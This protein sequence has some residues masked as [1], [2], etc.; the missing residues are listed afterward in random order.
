MM[1]ITGGTIRLNR[2][3]QPA[4][5]ALACELAAGEGV[6][7]GHAEN[8]RRD[9]RQDG[10]DHRRDEGARERSV[11]EGAQVPR[12]DR[13]EDHRRHGGGIDRSLERGQDDPQVRHRDQ[14]E[15]GDE[16]QPHDRA[17]T[18]TRSSPP[19]LPQR[20]T[21]RSRPMTR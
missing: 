17:S 2:S 1:K 3:I 6:A 8:E 7:G 13:R 5:E 15:A 21:H 4:K 9:R 10:D 18:A 19:R 11:H 20:A 16:E 14:D 12:G